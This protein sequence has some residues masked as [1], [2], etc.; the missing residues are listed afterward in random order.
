MSSAARRRSA[1]IE[2]IA[3]RERWSITRKRLRRSRASIFWAAHVNVPSTVRGS[4][5]LSPQAVE[6]TAIAIRVSRRQ[7]LYGSLDMDAR[8]CELFS[9]G[10]GGLEPQ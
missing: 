9:L 4:G 10:G 2:A 1:T 6:S 8:C 7:E 3:W 5:R